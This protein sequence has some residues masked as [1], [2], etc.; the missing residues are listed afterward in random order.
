MLME[1]AGGAY[2]K[3]S[4]VKVDQLMSLGSMFM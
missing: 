3:L 1:E 4:D 2:M